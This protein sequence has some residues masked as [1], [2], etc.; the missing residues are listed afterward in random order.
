[1]NPERAD[2]GDAATFTKP[3]KPDAPKPR[4]PVTAR[5]LLLST[6]LIFANCYWVLEVEG[7]WHTNHATAMSLFW[8]T[9]FCLL[10][11][12]GI[13][14][15]VLKPFAP[16]FAFSQGEL[17]TFFTMLTIG[18][19]LAGH[20]SLQLG[21]PGVMGFP[22]WFQEQQPSLGWDKFIRF[23]PDWV[24]VKDINILKPAYYGHATAELYTPKHLAAWSL[25]VGWWSA[26]T[27]ALGAVLVGTA[28]ILR[29]Q[30][31]EIEKLA[32]PVVQ[33]PL[34]L[35]DAD[36]NPSFWRNKL[37]L[38][39]VAAG[40]SL[41]IW[42]GLATLIPA[43][44]MIPVRHDQYN[45]G[46]Y[47]TSPPWNAVGNVPQPL[48]PFLVALGFLLP[49]DLSFS[50]WFFYLFR[51]ALRVVGVAFNLQAAP[52]GGS[53]FPY[54]TQQS[55][56]AWIV[57]SAIALWQ[58]RA[59][60]KA[61]WDKAW[62]SKSTAIDDSDEPL[63]YRAAFVC[64][65]LGLSFLL[66]FCLHAGMS[67]GIVLGFFGFYFLLSVGIG[68]LRAELGPPAH[69]MAGNMNGAALMTLFLGTQGVGLQNLTVLSLF[70]WFSG[71][72]YRTHPLPG[73]LE[74]MRLGR[75]LD[76]TGSLRGTGY[77]MLLAVLV[78]TIASFWAALHL[79]YGA[80][81]N[82]MTNHNWGQFQSVASAASAPQPPDGRGQIALLVGGLAALGMIWMRTQFV[83]WPFHPAGYAI[84]LTYGGEYYWS[85]LVIAWVA[86][87]LV[88]RYG[89]IGMY[90]RVVP[91]AFGVILG[92]YTV[93]A[94]WS[95]I[96]VFVNSGAIINIKTY[97]FAPG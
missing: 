25:P 55:F 92:E 34:A 13:N 58:A 89:G 46:Q 91:F 53:Q 11:L 10:I 97:D 39:G 28:T 8:N 70:Y 80:G 47:A 43:L 96:S 75:G 41:N 23:Y 72:G 94:L 88:L 78:G 84:A 31:T 51:L 15:A 24:M 81:I 45:L 64:I 68:R 2:V 5:I 61:A 66:Y 95:L 52:G 9:V 27:L 59:H 49:T 3:A 62:D 71:R 29:K 42:N 74:G 83:W 1:M 69:E 30:W 44:P 85:C 57:I 93:G 40:A 79:Q 35:I 12:V 18:T 77:A 67:W 21:I 32:Y 63:S 16:R 54:L 7:I 56:G 19:A 4:P 14:A 50:L 37:L 48:Y 87:S 38:W 82:A 6:V 76:G 26:F 65:A 20:D 60:L 73:M 22:V 86:K 90:R 17:A 36:K 33:L